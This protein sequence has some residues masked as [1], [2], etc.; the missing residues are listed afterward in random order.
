M[1][2]L[3]SNTIFFGICLLA[4]L[5]GL[6]LFA[7]DTG[8]TAPDPVPFDETVTVGLTLEEEQTL[9]RGVD[10]HVEP[11]RTQVFYSQYQYVVGYYG[12][13]TFVE[14][15]RQA[16]HEQRFGHP[17]TIYV[18]DYS[19][20][21]VTLTDEGYLTTDRPTGWT[22]AETAWF[23]VG[24]DAQLPGGD[25]VVPF[26]D[27]GAAQT[28]ADS[29]GG[30][31]SDWESVLD[32]SFETD[33]GALARDRVDDHHR[34]ADDRIEATDTDADRLTS[35]VVGT[36]TDT[37][38]AA[39]DRAPANT[40][41]VVPEGVYEEHVEIDRPITLAGDGNVTLRGNSTGTVLTVT[42]DHVTVTDVAID[43]V[44]E[45]TRGDGAIPVSVDDD[46]WDAAFRDNYAA[47]DAGIGAFLAEHLRVENVTI[48]TPANGIL[49]YGSQDAVVR[50]VTVDAPDDPSDGLA[51]V[52]LFQSPGVVES[53]TVAG[54]TNGIYLYRS[55][56]TV[57]RSNTIEGNR[58]GIHVMHTDD[59]LI[60]DNE[61]RNEQFVGVYI[62]TGPER[63]AVVGNTVD[64]AEVGFSVGGSEA[65]V[66]GNL[67]D[68][69]DTG[70]IVGTTA[71]IYEGNVLTGNEI[72]ADVT[73]MLPTNQFVENDFVGNDEHATTTAGPLRIWSDETGGNYWQGGARVASDRNVADRSYAPTDAV[74]RRL[75]LTDGTPTLVRSPARL[76]L[77]SL[78]GSVPGMQ[79]ASIVDRAPTCEPN[80]PEL[81]D[82]TEWGESA[83]G[84]YETTHTER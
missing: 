77:T 74:D 41:V 45:T 82:R 7:V 69:N 6:G 55:P 59:L 46:E 84:C 71:S 52:L 27:R 62:M 36:E 60:A 8:S 58:L 32:E 73:A 38:Q 24:S 70:L 76:T 30:T 54:G 57:V 33:D 3:S 9:D 13:E 23:V 26:A 48:E 53:T 37:V 18:S 63:N 68:R 20:T 51:G 83:W 10:E 31:V 47:T 17:L 19:D 43:G 34:L 15:Q 49:A 81:L 67:V 11:P 56:E 22:E 12:V 61:L 75:H 64:D 21:G 72:G 2:D 16:A 39:V 35:V 4:V 28:F 14:T 40:T 65:Y 1:L 66:A 5:G 50:N 78:E 80:N 79:T 29:Y 44:G 25:T 42:S